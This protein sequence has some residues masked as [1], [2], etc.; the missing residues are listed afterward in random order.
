[1]CSYPGRQR[2]QGG[3]LLFAQLAVHTPDP[4]CAHLTIVA[5]IQPADRSCEKVFLCVWTRRKSEAI[6][7][8][9]IQIGHVSAFKLQLASVLLR[10]VF[11]VD[12]LGEGRKDLVMREDEDFGGGDGVEP[13]LDPAPDCR[14][15]GWGAEDLASEVS[16]M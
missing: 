3:Y 16:R 9:R 14:E 15:E 8:G 4:Y 7:E 10:N 11:D 6:A 13:S 2:M 1:M 12:E 5:C